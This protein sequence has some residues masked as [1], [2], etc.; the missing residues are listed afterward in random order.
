M[1]DNKAFTFPG[2]PVL[3]GITVF[4]ALLGLTQ[5]VTYQHYLLFNSGRAREM[6]NAAGMAQDRLQ[7]ALSNSLSATQTL[8]FIIKKYGNPV[9]FD[10]VAKRILESNKFVDAM[11]LVEGGTITKVYPLNGNET[12]IGYNILADSATRI[13]AVK[14]IQKKQLFYAGPFKLKQGGV[15]ILG[16]L[17]IFIDGKFW[18]FSAALI[19]LSTFLQAAEMDS[20][21]NS[22]YIYQLSKVNPHT[23]QE[24]FFLPHPELFKNEASTS[25][26][27]SDGEWRIYALPKNSETL[28]SVIPL[29]L[30]GFLLSL[31]GGGFVFFITRQPFELKKLVEEK[32]DQLKST[33]E[34]YRVTL[35]RVS[36]AF[37]ALDKDWCFTYVNQKAGEIFS[38]NPEQII[39]KNFWVEFPELADTLFCKACY[40]AMQT[41][42]YIYLEAYSRP[43]NMWFENNIYPSANGLSIFFKDIS[44]RKKIDLALKQSEQRYRQLIE[45]IPEAVYTCD[46]EGY[47]VLYNKAA[48]R[49]WG[50]E[51][52]IGKD[53]WGGGAKLY[54]KDGVAIER[55]CSPLATALKTEKTGPGEEV[56]I[57]R[58]D[59]TRR[60]VLSHHSLLYNTSR[61][62]TGA[63]NMLVDI[64]ERRIAEGK[65]DIE[66]NYSDSIINSLPGVFYLFNSEGKYLRW[67]R[68]LEQVT[69]YTADEV[70]GMHPLDFFEGEEKETITQKI[71][72]VFTTGNTEVEA[73]LITKE[74]KRIP[75]FF[76]GHFGNFEG[77]NC[78]IGMGID[79]TERKKA[80]EEIVKSEKRFRHILDNMLE[81]V[82]IFDAGWR[83]IY[84]NDAAVSQGPYTK[85]KIYQY[86][87]LEN[88]PGIENTPLFK[89]FE[90]CRTN[91]LS[92]QIDYNFIFPDNSAKWFEL[93]IRPNPEGLFVLSVDIDERK[94]AEEATMASEKK[95]RYLFNN[96][97]AI[98]FV[99]DIESLKLLE[100]NETGLREF[101]YSY[102]EAMNMT[103]LDFRLKEEHEEIKESVKRMATQKEVTSKG[104]WRHIRRDGQMVYMDISTHRIN[105]GNSK[106]MLSVAENV[107]LKLQMEEQIKK[108]YDDIRLLN[109]HLET[110]REDERAFIA[111]EI[112]DQLGQQLTALKMDASWIS[113]KVII[114]DL[115]VAERLNS[116]IS[117]IDE[118]V[119]T[120]RR[121]ASDLRPGI[122]DDLG[123]MAALEWQSTEFEKRTGTKVGFVTALTEID[124]GKK[125]SIDIFRVYQE[126]LTNIAR[127][128][129]ATVVETEIQFN[130]DIF[131]LSVKDNGNGFDTDQVKSKNTLGLIGMRERVAML[132]GQLIIESAPGKGTQIT[133]I[134][135]LNKNS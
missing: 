93:S 61:K 62:V 63:V 37:V 130:G 35:E 21:S 127:H 89:I 38:R 134:V 79:I 50:R 56:I 95:F 96:N 78:L 34:N 80:E 83:N 2:R 51:P 15:G 36:D 5:F 129:H 43:Y 27:V 16:R 133:V 110:I 47:V 32:S 109:S 7:T 70:S 14:A 20:T 108:S 85:E 8:S 126:I 64:T 19:K 116:M 1:N 84:I 102:E 18:G 9:D 112:H 99:W 87:L 94:K 105:Y 46:A 113:K 58:Y 100:V 72:E 30:L 65:A 107:T 82:Q 28:V 54:S 48:I 39:G 111:R 86:S 125:C 124:L 33:E 12:V 117:L 88:Y 13:E 114:A 31:T 81:G 68:N 25:V 135:P 53:K 66:K 11:E 75:Y 10:T 41:Q 26:F 121:I 106:A 17:P 101:G 119:K 71:K 24:E 42:K 90:E 115:Q 69:G 77:V 91:G 59:G 67:N 4:L 132:N 104:T 52:E 3:V 57:E 45:E 49:L 97:P 44:E 22:P 122:L 120:V 76:N 103:L 74:G 98:I 60:N 29:L 73:T 6:H 40:S 128:A 55:E 123:L 131:T 92:K 23:G 118:T